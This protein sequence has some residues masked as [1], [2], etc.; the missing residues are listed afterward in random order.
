MDQE[1]RP[2][3]RADAHLQAIVRAVVEEFAKKQESKTEPAYKVELVEERKRR[4]QLEQRVNELVEENSK[5]RQMAEEAER[6]A[7]IRGEL[8]RLGVAKVDLAFRAV[9][10]DIYRTEDGRLA[11]RDEQGEKGLK[12]YLAS[13][14]GANPEFLPARITG[15]SGATANP[16]AG[17]AGSGGIEIEKIK[18]GMSKEEIEKVRQE[19][20][21]IADQ[22]L[23]GL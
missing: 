22:S 8:Q 10:D 4:E 20:A 7:T 21:R 11:A 9:K 3:E 5:S 19:I 1:L 13:F 6:G 15:G 18:P 12:E 2:G 14:L 16:K 17:V 23:R